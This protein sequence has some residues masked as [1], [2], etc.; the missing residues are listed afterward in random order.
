MGTRLRPGQGSPNECN[1][2]VYVWQYAPDIQYHDGLHAFQESPHSS[3][4]NKR[5]LSEI[6]D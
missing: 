6:R 3:P 2:D 4:I 1:H 5:G